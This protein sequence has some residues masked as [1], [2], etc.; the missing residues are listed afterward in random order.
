MRACW[1]TSCL[2]VWSLLRPL[3]DR[4]QQRLTVRSRPV[5]AMAELFLD[6]GID[7]FQHALLEPIEEVSEE[8][9][10]HR[11]AQA[12]GRRVK[13][14]AQALGHLAELALQGLGR[15]PGNGLGDAQHRSQKAQNRHGPGDKARQTVAPL[16]ADRII[17][18]QGAH[19]IVQPLGRAALMDEIK[20]ALDAPSQPGD[21]Q[22][23]RQTAHL[24]QEK[25]G[26]GDRDGFAG[27]GRQGQLG[28]GSFFLLQ[29]QEL[30]SQ[31]PQG[32]SKEDEGG[33]LDRVNQVARHQG[34]VDPAGIQGA[35]EAGRQGQTQQQGTGDG[36]G[37]P[38]WLACGR[39]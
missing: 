26:L 37:S 5:E 27:P 9:H 3:V 13:G 33:L 38:G 36:A 23:A 24:G 28:K 16:Q 29:L 11:Q 10:D 2:V 18:G 6:E 17:V 31:G 15:D 25:T 35:E 7:P 39:R 12:Q 21:A 19:L 30:D 8:H 32:A 4:C 20:Q 22:P 1:W 34:L 14:L